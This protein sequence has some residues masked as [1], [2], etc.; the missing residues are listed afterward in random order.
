MTFCLGCSQSAI[1]PCHIC[2]RPMYCSTEC[3]YRCAD[4]HLRNCFVPI[5][6]DFIKEVLGS[7]PFSDWMSRVVEDVS[8]THKQQDGIAKKATKSRMVLRS[9]AKK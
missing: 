6:V 4:K 5:R 2:G 1:K 3:A 8:K 7:N 9:G